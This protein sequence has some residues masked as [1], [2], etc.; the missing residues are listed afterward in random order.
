MGM[1]PSTKSPDTIFL[2]ARIPGQSSRISCA[3][4]AI[5]GMSVNIGRFAWS[6]RS[7]ILV[8]KGHQ[9]CHLHDRSDQH[10][11]SERPPDSA[12]IEAP[13]GSAMACVADHATRS[14]QNC[15]YVP[16][17]VDYVR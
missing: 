4:T 13:L 15:R 11:C 2:L 10:C 6:G 3:D 14:D 16:G 8:T 12:S 1:V 17:C 9:G 7:S 5:G